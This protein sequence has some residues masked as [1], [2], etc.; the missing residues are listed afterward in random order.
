LWVLATYVSEVGHAEVGDAVSLG[1]PP[2]SGQL[3]V[4]GVEA[5][6]E[7]GDFAEPAVLAG[8]GDAVMQVGD[9][10]LQPWCL[11]GVGA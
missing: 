3:L 8:F 10:A 7:A 9:D 6:F 11:F 1:K 2:H 4:C 5:G